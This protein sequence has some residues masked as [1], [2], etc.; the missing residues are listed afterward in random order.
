MQQRISRSRRQAGITDVFTGKTF[1]RSALQPPT[2]GEPTRSPEMIC[3]DEEPP[4]LWGSAP[5]HSWGIIGFFP[6]MPSLNVPSCTLWLSP[7]SSVTCCCHR[8]SFTPVPLETPM[9]EL[10]AAHPSASAPDQTS[11]PRSPG[12]RASRQPFTGSTPLL[13][14]AEQLRKLWFSFQTALQRE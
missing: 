6:P 4:P 5:G 12:C 13:N 1:W 9:Q 11:L 10:Q 3:K 2:H 8:K 7:L 14:S